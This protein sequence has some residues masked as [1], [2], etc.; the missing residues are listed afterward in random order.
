MY[1]SNNEPLS[2]YYGAVPFII[3]NAKSRLCMNK[4]ENNLQT[5]KT[6]T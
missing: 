6:S 3:L 2:F 5:T 1:S 4:S